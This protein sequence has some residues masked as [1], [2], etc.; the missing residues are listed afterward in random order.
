[1][2]NDFEAK[3]R[4]AEQQTRKFGSS[5]EKYILCIGTPTKAYVVEGRKDFSQHNNREATM[6][7]WFE[8][9]L[10]LTK[11]EQASD[12]N[13][14]Y[15]L[16]HFPPGLHTPDCYGLTMKHVQDG[17]I[18]FGGRFMS[19]CVN[20]NEDTTVELIQYFEELADLQDDQLRA[21]LSEFGF[22]IFEK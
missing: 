13:R 7:A 4:L 16:T 6:I 1:M 20:D 21:H 17:T 18:C 10:G 22:G 19:D 12:L 3:K 2:Q 15:R 14:R 8:F 11:C 9:L 5:P